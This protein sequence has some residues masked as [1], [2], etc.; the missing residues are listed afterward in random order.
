MLLSPPDS[1]TLARPVSAIAGHSPVVMGQREGR[2]HVNVPLPGVTG[3]P[4]PDLDEPF[5]QPLDGAPHSLALDVEPAKHVKQVVGQGPHLEAG[6]IGPEAVA[7]GLVPA[8]GVFALLD[9]V[10]DISS[11]AVDLHHLRPVG[12]GVGHDK[13]HVRDQLIRTPF[14]LA[15]HP[16]GPCPALGLIGKIHHLDLMPAPGR[17]AD[18]ACHMGRNLFI[19]LRVGAKPEEIGDPLL[20]AVLVGIRACEGGVA[21]KPEKP[22]PGTVSLHNREEEDQGSIRRV[23]VAWPELRAQADTFARE[24]KQGMITVRPEVAV[25]SNSLLAA[26]GRVLGRINVDDQPPLA[27][28]PRQSV[29]RAP[30]R[31]VQGLEPGLVAKNIVLQP[32][33]HGL[34]CSHLVALADGKAKRWIDSEMVGV[35]TILVARRVLINTLPDHLDQGVFGVYG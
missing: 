11:T 1:T 16:A 28:L 10:L 13:I 3:D 15:H 32:R 23:N 7:T 20:L 22:E 31:S 4:G 6:L 33:E 34:A 12:P 35:V 17:T 14:Q 24:G 29:G 18:R 27:L 19:E 25:T 2:G 30:R 9:P 5:D 8:K 26:A 21:P